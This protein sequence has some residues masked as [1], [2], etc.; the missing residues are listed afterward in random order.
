MPQKQPML[1]ALLRPIFNAECG[2]QARELVGDA[3]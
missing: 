3:L 1:V 2:E